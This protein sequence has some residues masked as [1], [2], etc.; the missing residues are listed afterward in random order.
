MALFKAQLNA[1]GFR[2]GEIVDVD[3]DEFS[4]LIERGWLKPHTEGHVLAATGPA[5][6]EQ[7]ETTD[8]ASASSPDDTLGDGVSPSN[9]EATG[10][11]ESG[12][13]M[14]VE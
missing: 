5:S 7:P 1:A 8:D 11:V 4:N 13:V 9:D 3:P 14:T 10:Y 12:D 6:G 2:R